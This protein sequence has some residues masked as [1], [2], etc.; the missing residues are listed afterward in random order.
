ML[1][2]DG[3]STPHKQ[4]L[5]ASW[6]TANPEKEKRE[7]ADNLPEDF[8]SW[9]PS[10]RLLEVWCVCVCES[11]SARARESVC[12]CTYTHSRRSAQWKWA[13]KSCVLCACVYCVC[14]CSLSLPPSLP[15]F[16][17]RSLAHSRTGG[18][19][20]G[21]HARERPAAKVLPAHQQTPC[22]GM[23]RRQLPLDVCTGCGWY[24]PL[25]LVSAGRC[26]SR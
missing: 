12:S 25:H 8:E 26:A 6:N 17:S 20:C 14:T 7:L 16:L 18:N 2:T 24:L 19:P 22:E 21:G 4:T 10:A 13:L 11:E 1:C 9:L 23:R 3:P 5:V 15:P